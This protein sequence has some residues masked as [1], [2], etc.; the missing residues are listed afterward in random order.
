MSTAVRRL[1]VAGVLAGVLWLTC[2]LPA[3]RAGRQASAGG[4]SGLHV[5]G[6]QILNDA[7]VP[8]LLHGVNRSGVEVACVQGWRIFDGPSDAAS[9]QAIVSWHA[10]AVRLPLNEDCWLGINGVNPAYSGAAYQKAIGSFVA[11]LTGSGF[12]VVLDLHLSAPG[13]QLATAQQPMPDIDHAPAFWTS[14]AGAFS[15]NSAVLFDL[16][17]EPFPNSNRDTI[18]AWQCLRDGGACPGGVIPR[19]GHADAG[20]R[21]ARQRRGQ[22]AAGAGGAVRGLAQPLAGVRSP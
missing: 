3:A 12:A 22:P 18:A 8:V 20:G 13:T 7:A 5:L 6:N 10:N 4:M 1:A 14:V 21:G 15:G 17:N 9:V 16:F 19:G 2:A 11:L